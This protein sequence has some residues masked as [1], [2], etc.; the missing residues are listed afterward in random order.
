MTNKGFS[1]IIQKMDDEAAKQT[2]TKRPTWQWIVIYLVIGAILYGLFYYFFL[3]KKN[4][5]PY[6]TP[7]PTYTSPTPAPSEAMMKGEMKV[8]LSEVNQSGQSGTATLKEENG[9]TTVT[10]ELVGFVKDVAQ[11]A[12]I[13]IG[14]CP[15]VGAVKYP[16]TNVVNGK[17]STT[18][19]PTLKD[20]KAQLPL[21]IN[22][23]KS[24]A[25]ISSYTACGELPSK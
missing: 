25:E 16:L 1:G 15:G 13:H 11:P 4:T 7:T 5:N 22:V 24:A 14:S 3:A 20:L 23:H 8:T 19:S 18:I 9:K 2:Y 6:K 17:S 10:V 12:H 21:A